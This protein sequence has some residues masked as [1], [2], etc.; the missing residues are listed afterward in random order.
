[1]VTKNIILNKKT[2]PAGYACR[3]FT[4]Y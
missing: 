4:V 2:K 3:Q 1:M